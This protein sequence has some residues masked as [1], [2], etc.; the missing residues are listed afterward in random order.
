MRWPPVAA[1]LLI[2]PQLVVETDGWHIPDPN[3]VVGFDVAFGIGGQVEVFG[4]W[5]A[6]RVDPAIAAVQHQVGAVLAEAREW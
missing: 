3:D 2:L 6:A 5:D 4:D 1:S